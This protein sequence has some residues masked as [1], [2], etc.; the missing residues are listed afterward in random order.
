M[1]YILDLIESTYDTLSEIDIVI[2]IYFNLGK[3][4]R[5]YRGQQ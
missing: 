5:M 4:S 1:S 2:T 3:D